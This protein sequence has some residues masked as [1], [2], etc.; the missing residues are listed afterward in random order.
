MIQEAFSEASKPKDSHKDA[1]LESQVYTEH[2]AEV[3]K[4]RE[5]IAKDDIFNDRGVLLVKKGK[6][7]TPEITQAIVQF[8]L[9][10]PIQD[11]ITIKNEL[12][13]DD[14][15]TDL[16][17]LINADPSLANIQLRYDLVSL[18]EQ[19]CKRYDSFAMLRQKITVMSE[20]L[21]TIYER[22]LC[23]SWLA[24]LIAK[25][26]RLPPDDVAN[27]FLAALAHDIGMLHISPDILDKKGQ[28]TPEEWRQMQAHAVIGKTILDAI[29][30][31]P[32]KVCTAVLEHHERCDGTGYPV[33][34]VESELCLI[35][36]IIALA[37]SVIA[38]YFNRFKA[39]GRSWRDVIPVIQ[40]NSQVYLYRNYEVL[41]T[42]LRRSELARSAV[43]ETDSMP[44]FI[45]QLIAKNKE[46][47]QWFDTLSGSMRSVG[48]THGDRKLHALQNVLI[49]VATAV[50]GSGIFQEGFIEWL[51]QVKQQ[52]LTTD[53][54][55]VED[56]Y[57]MQEEVVFHLQRLNRMAK[58][59]LDSNLNGN[60]KILEVLQGGLDQS[61]K[62]A[63]F[64]K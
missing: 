24:L 29:D 61:A 3:N 38:V 5:V 13:G 43:H 7:I 21:P 58:I 46:L 57:L 4:S 19:Q 50:A 11:S 32:K 36:Q 17:Q 20:R 37:D 16:T 59:Y 8:K 30:N 41:V 15:L 34:K 9:L 47:K 10:K 14:L 27:T 53:Y 26:M 23:C 54:A 49:H 40:M 52:Q 28:L 48:Y 64:F 35:G 42:I 6:P 33:G 25:E 1:H 44:T 63:L 18:L 51:E 60:K 12:S 31:I 2:L 56:V 22:T 62:L 45:D 55:E 39:E